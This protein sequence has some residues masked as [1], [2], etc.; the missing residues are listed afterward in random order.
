MALFICRNKWEKKDQLTCFNI[1][2]HNQFRGDRTGFSHSGVEE[3]PRKKHR[4]K[5]GTRILI[6]DAINASARKIQKVESGVSLRCARSILVHTSHYSRLKKPTTPLATQKRLPRTGVYI[7][8]RTC[9]Y[10]Y[11][12]Q[13]QGNFRGKRRKEIKRK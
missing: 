3:C 10:A 9:H 13:T 7:T 5:S 8:C 12:R 2:S 4:N 11:A 6:A 1:N